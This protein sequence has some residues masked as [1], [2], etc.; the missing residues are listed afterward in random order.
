MI[1]LKSLYEAWQYCQEIISLPSKEIEK[2]PGEEFASLFIQAEK[3]LI[4]EV[5]LLAYD[6]G[7]KPVN[8]WFENSIRL[9]DYEGVLL[10]NITIGFDML[11]F[12]KDYKCIVC[13]IIHQLC[14]T[15][16]EK[17]TKTFWKLY[18]KCLSTKGLISSDYNGWKTQQNGEIDY[19][20]SF[21]KY[22]RST[23][24]YIIRR[25]L[26]EKVWWG[27]YLDLRSEYG[28]MRAYKYEH[29]NKWKNL[30]MC[31]CGE[32]VLWN[33]SQMIREILDL[34]SFV[35]VSATKK[36]PLKLH[37][38]K[39][40][41]DEKEVL[42]L[43][44][45]SR[46][47]KDEDRISYC[48]NQMNTD[49]RYDFSPYT[50]CLINLEVDENH[51]LNLEEDLDKLKKIKINNDVNL[52]ITYSLTMRSHNLNKCEMMVVFSK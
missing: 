43:L 6:L 48:V 26:F 24:Y 21:K 34:E 52:I 38:L 50:S 42:C 12:S 33:V 22:H 44:Y 3:K 16:Y 37:D 29:F 5:Y 15:I 35:I 7:F 10:G 17:R 40:L 14:R 23:K 31:L 51:P 46:V 30:P 36:K 28:D 2:I 45:D 39:Y 19:E 20:V 27:D 1:E 49:D 32:S 4:S 18:E 8:S 11:F 9:S 41:K 47:K 13:V 25:K